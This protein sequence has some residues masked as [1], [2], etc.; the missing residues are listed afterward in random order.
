MA[1]SWIRADGAGEKQ[2]IFKTGNNIASYS[3]TPDGKTLIITELPVETGTDIYALPLDLSDPEHPKAG[4]PVPLVKT[5]MSESFP[6]LSGDGKWLAYTSTE[7][8]RW[9][10]YVK[11][12]PS[13]SGRWQISSDGGTT[14]LWAPDGRSLYF[15]HDSHIYVADI[16]A[17]GDAIAAGRPRL[18][19]P[20]P[21]RL[22]GDNLSYAIHPDGQR[23][24]VYPAAPPDPEEKGNAH[25]T[26]VFNFLDD[27]K[28]RIEAAK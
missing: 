1:I 6:I 19:S 5:P 28:R 8:G 17:Q 9:E 16:T 24:A 22:S 14:P 13:L 2:V 11:P 18:W 7:S 25:V 3:F 21:V 27:M 23:F 4:Q 10:V 15:V 20:T 26:F 12:Y